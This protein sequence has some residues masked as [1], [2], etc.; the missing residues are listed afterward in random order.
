MHL[1]CEIVCFDRTKKY[2]YFRKW[3]EILVG[4]GQCVLCVLV[5]FVF[6]P[7]KKKR[8]DLV[9]DLYLFFVIDGK[10]IECVAVGICL[11]FDRVL[12]APLGRIPMLFHSH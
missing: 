11:R 1:K 5:Y 12:I 8:K 6:F 10:G 3:R 9:N 7:H 2:L 4:V